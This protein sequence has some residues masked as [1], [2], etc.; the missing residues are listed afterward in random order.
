MSFRTA[1]LVSMLALVGAI[2]GCVALAV[3]QVVQRSAETELALDLSRG[4]GVAN[5]AWSARRA[6]EAAQSR[7]VAEEP[8]LKAV[9]ATTDITHATIVGVA[10][11][12]NRG[13]HADVFLVTDSD[14]FLLG[15]V[16]H[17]DDEGGDLSGMALIQGALRDGDAPG[18]LVDDEHVYR[19]HAQRLAFGET[20]VGVLVLGNAVDAALAQTIETETGSAFVALLGERVV[21]SSTE[22][23]PGLPAD[24]VAAIAS[25]LGETPHEVTIGGAR[26]LATART[27]EARADDEPL[28][29]VL[30]AS[31]DRALEPSR[32]LI[33]LLYVLAGIGLSLGAILALLLARALSRPLDRMVAFAARVAGGDLAAT[34][35][36]GGLREIRSLGAALDRMVAE[37]RRSQETLATKQRLEKEFEI[38]SRLQTALLPVSPKAP[39]LDVAARMV[40]ATEVGG[41]YYDVLPR[42]DRGAW[43]AIGDVAGHGLLAG[44]VMLMVR[45]A[46]AALV[47]RDPDARPAEMVARLN[48]LLHEGVRDRLGGDQH[49]TFC[50]LRYD[51]GGKFLFAGAHEDILV[52][53]KATRKVEAIATSGAWLAVS[54]SVDRVTKDAELVLAEGDTMVLMTDGVFENERPDRTI[55]GLDAVI[56]DIEA[57]DA[58]ETK[59]PEQIVQHVIDFVKR[60]TGE[61]ADDVTLVV[62]RRQ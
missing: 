18:I 8:R 35:S 11:E 53:R 49:V 24:D 58:L 19:V 36:T 47:E 39:G 48:R 33:R 20:T 61:Q 17:P 40:P 59:S 38:A 28:R 6:L 30:L 26:Y 34:A 25:S 45:T 31:L 41:D 1:L 62:V 44:I 22:S 57:I 13:L 14:G 37:L 56:A 4:Q 3:A 29:Y 50:V 60:S 55:L 15:D 46:F 2:V 54:D 10:Q 23:A 7:V 51:G 42:G 9:V 16:A 43:L 32:A 5:E 12:I 21:A 52:W 27:L